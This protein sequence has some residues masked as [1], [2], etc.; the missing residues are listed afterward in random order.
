VNLAQ[1]R[2]WAAYQ[3][4]AAV[5]ANVATLC[6]ALDGALQASKLLAEENA[7]LAA[8]ATLTHVWVVRGEWVRG[9]QNGEVAWIVGV[10]SHEDAARAMAEADRNELHRINSQVGA[11]RLQDEPS[12]DD[13]DAFI[14]WDEVPIYD[15]LPRTGRPA[16]PHEEAPDA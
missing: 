4:S 1:M 11:V 10:A 9:S 14:E 16:L 5:R 12:G 13:P 6:D 2:E 3:H 15:L 8:L 7:R